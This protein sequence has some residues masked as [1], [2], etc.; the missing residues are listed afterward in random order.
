V[1]D[2][3]PG[4]EEVAPRR[5]P[6]MSRGDVVFGIAIGLVLAAVLVAVIPDARHHM[7]GGT[8]RRTTTVVDAFETTRSGSSDRVVGNYRVA[9]TDDAGREHTSTFKRSGPLRHA[10]GDRVELWVSADRAT[11][12][13]E[14]PLSLWLWLG[15]GLPVASLFIGL[16]RQWRHRMY[17][18]MTLRD[19]ERRDAR[20]ARRAR[21]KAIDR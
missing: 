9:W 8:D 11:A 6:W 19:I 21:R 7:L 4:F 12:T 2:P 1:S 3:R 15:L 16:V 5:R 13:Q 18:R 17:V 10:V 14:S 20:R